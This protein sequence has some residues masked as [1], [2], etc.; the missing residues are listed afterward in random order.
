MKTYEDFNSEQHGV[1]NY[2]KLE[3]KFW[4]PDRWFRQTFW[5][6]VSL[7]QGQLGATEEDRA[8]GI[9][10]GILPIQIWRDISLCHCLQTLGC[11]GDEYAEPLEKALMF[12]KIF[13][14]LKSSPALLEKIPSFVCLVF[15]IENKWILK[16][17]NLF[18]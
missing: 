13:A 9:Q 14:K 12:K 10:T 16:L 3:D 6:F 11:E 15:K 1:A 7:P 18:S 17:K 8:R 5:S 4:K 2:W